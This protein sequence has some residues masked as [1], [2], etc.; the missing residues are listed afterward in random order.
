M[1]GVEGVYSGASADYCQQY[2]EGAMLRCKVQWRLLEVT[3]VLLKLHVDVHS[4]VKEQAHSLVVVRKDC[5]EQA[6][7]WLG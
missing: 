2:A 1:L 7:K 4:M 6:L 5:F 3:F